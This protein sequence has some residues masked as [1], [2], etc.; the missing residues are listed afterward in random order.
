MG[1]HTSEHS[2]SGV[3]LQQNSSRSMTRCTRRAS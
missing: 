1:V 2:T 3:I